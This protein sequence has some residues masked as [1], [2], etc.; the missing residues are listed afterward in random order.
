MRGGPLRETKHAVKNTNATK[1]TASYRYSCVFQF[2]LKKQQ[3]GR[4]KNR[5]EPSDTE[6]MWET[7]GWKRMSRCENNRGRLV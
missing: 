5:D 2:Q 6:P 3:V 1:Q 7:V 4:P